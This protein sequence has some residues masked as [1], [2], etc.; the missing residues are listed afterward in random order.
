MTEHICLGC[1][2]PT[3]HPSQ[4][5]DQCSEPILGVEC[6]GCGTWCDWDAL[7]DGKCFCCR[8]EVEDE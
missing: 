8:E 6:Q 7:Q 5:C 3:T 4:I 1:Q 2:A